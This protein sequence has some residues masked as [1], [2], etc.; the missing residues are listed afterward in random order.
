M[1]PW[2][3]LLAGFVL[4]CLAFI[5]VWV[6]QLRTRNAGMVD[7]VWSWSMG[8]LGVLYALCGGGDPTLR[9]VVGLIAGT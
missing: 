5:A 2:N 3:V 7:P 8:A 4:T 6:Q 9:W 1:S